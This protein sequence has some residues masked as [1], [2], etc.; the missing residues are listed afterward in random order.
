MFATSSNHNVWITNILKHI[1]VGPYVRKI[2]IEICISYSRGHSA[3]H[4]DTKIRYLAQFF[5]EFLQTPSF[6]T[7][8]MKDLTY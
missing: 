4:F 6:K 5:T 8:I 1:C 2:K 3:G 7:C